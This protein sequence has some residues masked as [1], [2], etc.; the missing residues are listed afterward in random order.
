MFS[1]WTVYDLF[2]NGFIKYLKMVEKNQKL[3]E[4][5]SKLMHIKNLAGGKIDSRP[6]DKA[7][8]EKL[9]DDKY[10][11]STRLHYKAELENVSF[12]KICREAA[13]KYVDINGNDF[14][15]RQLENTFKSMNSTSILTL[16][17][18]RIRAGILKYLQ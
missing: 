14:T 4:Y 6:E 15:G 9:Q 13:E 18:L 1:Y 7:Q 11:F 5:K 8:K 12:A 16:K 2:F 10:L 17:D 3:L